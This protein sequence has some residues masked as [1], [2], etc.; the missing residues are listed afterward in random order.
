MYVDIFSF[1]GGKLQSNKYH[2]TE[3]K[4]FFF[5]V[6][7]QTFRAPNNNQLIVSEFQCKLFKFNSFGLFQNNLDMRAQQMVILCHHVP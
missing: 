5:L 3:Q 2:L 7:C 1:F 4:R 6:E